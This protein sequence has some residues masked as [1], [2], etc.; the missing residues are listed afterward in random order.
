MISNSLLDVFLL[1]FLNLFSEFLTWQNCFKKTLANHQALAKLKQVRH[2][3]EAKKKTTKL[4]EKCRRFT[5]KTRQRLGG[6][7]F[8]T[9]FVVLWHGTLGEDFGGRWLLTTGK[10]NETKITKHHSLPYQVWFSLWSCWEHLCKGHDPK[11]SSRGISQYT[12][13][14]TTCVILQVVITWNRVKGAYEM[15]YFAKW[16]NQ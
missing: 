14:N 13:N 12:N 9:Y 16:S 5:K 8:Q 4:T 10:S 2:A 11:G 6:Y 7:K 1:I 3:L 15:V